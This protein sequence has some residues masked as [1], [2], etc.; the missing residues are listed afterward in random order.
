M[1]IVLLLFSSL[2]GMLTG[3][4]PSWRARL[5]GLGG[6]STF[7]VKDLWKADFARYD[8]IVVFGVAE[9]MSELRGKLAAELRPHSTVVAC[10]FPL[11]GAAAKHILGDGIDTVGDFLVRGF[12]YIVVPF[13]FSPQVLLLPRMKVWIYPAAAVKA[14]VSASDLPTAKKAK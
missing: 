6:V 4:A 14:A 10:R 1:P 13:F 3:V 12:K 2:R 11:P 9:M 8:D 5:G 7:K